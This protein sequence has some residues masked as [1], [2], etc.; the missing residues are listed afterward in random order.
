MSAD[1]LAVLLG[2]AGALATTWAATEVHGYLTWV[3][4]GRG[5]HRPS[6]WRLRAAVYSGCVVLGGVLG[7]A[8]GAWLRG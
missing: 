2:T 1:A 7:L 8:L 3:R 4:R 5:G 6:R